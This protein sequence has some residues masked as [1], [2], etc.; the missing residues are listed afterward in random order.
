MDLDIL[1]ASGG[2]D[3]A[4]AAKPLVTLT[5]ISPN[6]TVGDIKKA[7]YRQR[8]SLYPERQALRSEPRGKA[9]KDDVQLKT[10]DLQNGRNLYIKDLGPQI[11][12]STVFI[13]EYAGPLFAYLL[14]YTRPAWL[15]GHNAGQPISYVVHL[16]AICW[17]IHYVK[18]ILETLFVH[19]F[20]HSTMPLMNLFKNCSYYWGFAFYIG[21]YVNH[22]LYT[23][24]Y[25]GKLQ[26]YSS[27][28]GFLLFEFGNLSIHLALRDLRPAGS[29]ERRIPMPTANPFTILF[30][31]VSC[32][33]Y[34]YEWYSW[35]AFSVM[36][37]CLP[38]AMFTAAGF[39]QMAIWALAK[40]R[41]YKKEFPN[42]PRNRKAIVPFIL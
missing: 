7:I 29:T 37:Q 26:V 30:Q 13:C 34:A 22:P 9:L 10:L 19:R 24:P 32:P 27:L 14:S 21:Y 5:D 36:T 2:K 20:S 8:R 16:A 23:E 42:Y 11:G 41:N 3:A 28:I 4:A 18:R 12:W 17:S 33:N 38:A 35:A 40:H 31:Y 25:L 6:S 1:K 39:I 15:Y